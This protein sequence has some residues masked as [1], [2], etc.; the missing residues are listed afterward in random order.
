MSEEQRIAVAKAIAKAKL[1]VQASDAELNGGAAVSTPALAPPVPTTSDKDA[2]EEMGAAPVAVVPAPG[3]VPAG[4]AAGNDPSSSSDDDE[5]DDDDT[6]SGGGGGARG[7]DG[8]TVDQPTRNPLHGG[9][10]TTGAEVASAARFPVHNYFGEPPAEADETAGRP[11]VTTYPGGSAIFNSEGGIMLFLPTRQAVE[12]STLPIIPKYRDPEVPA[13]TVYLGSSTIEHPHR[14]PAGWALI[15]LHIGDPLALCC[16]D[17]FDGD[18]VIPEDELKWLMTWHETRRKGMSRRDVELQEQGVEALVGFVKGGVLPH[19]GIGREHVNIMTGMRTVLAQLIEMAGTKGLVNPDNFPDLQKF[20]EWMGSGHRLVNLRVLQGIATQLSTDTPAYRTSTGGEVAISGTSFPYPDEIDVSGGNIMATSVFQGDSHPSVMQISCK[21]SDAVSEFLTHLFFLVR[22]VDPD[23][24]WAAFDAVMQVPFVQTKITSAGK[25]KSQDKVHKGTPSKFRGRSFEWA[26]RE[27]ESRV[28]LFSSQTNRGYAAAANACALQYFS[29][30]PLCQGEIE[31]GAFPI[32]TEKEK[33]KLAMDELDEE[34]LE[35][36]FLYPQSC[37]LMANPPFKMEGACFVGKPV[38][39]PPGTLIDIKQECK[40]DQRLS[41]MSIPW[42]YHAFSGMTLMALI[43]DPSF[44]AALLNNAIGTMVVQSVDAGQ[45][46]MKRPPIAT[47]PVVI[48]TKQAV[49]WESLRLPGMT[50][51]QGGQG[52]FQLSGTGLVSH[53][54]TGVCIVSHTLWSAQTGLVAHSVGAAVLLRAN[55]YV[56]MQEHFE[57][58]KESFGGTFITTSDAG[59]ATLQRAIPLATYLKLP[60]DAEIKGWTNISIRH[61]KEVTADACRHMRSLMSGDHSTAQHV[62]LHTSNKSGKGH[63]NASAAGDEGAAEPGDDEGGPASKQSKRRAKQKERKENKQQSE[64]GASAVRDLSAKLAKMQRQLDAA[65]AAADKKHP[66][67]RELRKASQQAGGKKPKEANRKK[68]DS[69]DEDTKWV[70]TGKVD[71]SK[72]VSILRKGRIRE[73][74]E[75]YLPNLHKLSPLWAAFMDGEPPKGLLKEIAAANT[76]DKVAVTSEKSRAFGRRAGLMKGDAIKV[77]AALIAMAKAATAGTLIPAHEEGDSEFGTLC[78]SFQTPSST[79]PIE[80]PCLPEEQVWFSLTLEADGTSDADCAQRCLGEIYQHTDISCLYTEKNIHLNTTGGP[81]DPVCTFSSTKYC[82]EDGGD[83]PC[84]YMKVRSDDSPKED[85]SRELSAFTPVIQMN[86]NTVQAS[87]GEEPPKGTQL[88]WTHCTSQ[89]RFNMTQAQEEFVL[90]EVDCSG[91]PSTELW[92]FTVCYDSASGIPVCGSTVGE[93]P[94]GDTEV[95]SYSI[96]SLYDLLFN[97]NSMDN[98]QRFGALAFWGAV[99]AVFLVLLWKLI[100]FLTKTIQRGQEVNAARESAEA[101]REASARIVELQGNIERIYTAVASNDLEDDKATAMAGDPLKWTQEQAAAALNVISSAD[102]IIMEGWQKYEGGTEC[103]IN[104]FAKVDA[105]TM[106]SR[107]RD[108]IFAELS[109]SQ[110]T[111]PEVT[112]K[113]KR[114]FGLGRGV[115]KVSNLGTAAKRG[116]CTLAVAAIFGVA[117]GSMYGCAEYAKLWDGICQREVAM[118]PGCDSDHA[119]CCPACFEGNEAANRT[120]EGWA[121]GIGSTNTDVHCYYAP[122]VRMA[123]C[124]A[125]VADLSAQLTSLEENVSSVQAEA[126]NMSAKLTE[127]E[128]VDEMLMSVDSEVLGFF[129][130]LNGSVADVQSSLASF[131][132]ALA[133]HASQVT[134][135][136]ASLTTVAADVAKSLQRAA[137][138]DTKATSASSQV[139]TLTSTASALRADI[140]SIQTSYAEVANALG[141]LYLSASDHDTAITALEGEFSDVTA[142]LPGL[143]AGIDN[144]TAAAE[145]AADVA[146]VLVAGLSTRILAVENAA[147]QA[148]DAV[149]DL[150]GWNSTSAE[151]VAGLASLLTSY[152]STLQEVG[153]QVNRVNQSF[154]DFTEDWEDDVFDGYVLINAS[155]ANTQVKVAGIEAFIRNLTNAQFLEVLDQA[156]MLESDVGYLW[157]DLKGVNGTVVDQSADISELQAELRNVNET[158]QAAYN[159]NPDLQR[160]RMTTSLSRPDQQCDMWVVDQISDSVSTLDGTRSSGFRGT[161]TG[162]PGAV[163]CF[164]YEWQDNNAASSAFGAVKVKKAGQKHSATSGIWSGAVEAHKDNTYGCG[165][166]EKYYDGWVVGGLESIMPTAYGKLSLNSTNLVSQQKPAYNRDCVA[167]SQAGCPDCYDTFNGLSM[168]V[169]VSGYN[170]QPPG[171]HQNADRATVFVGDISEGEGFTEVETMLWDGVT[172]EAVDEYEGSGTAFRLS[173]LQC[174]TDNYRVSS[175]LPADYRMF[176][177]D[178]YANF[179][180]VAAPIG[181][182]SSSVPGGNIQAASK[183][184]LWDDALLNEEFCK[185]EYNGNSMYWKCATDVLGELLEGAQRSGYHR[186]GDTIGGC[187]IDFE[188][189]T[190]ILSCPITFDITCYLDGKTADFEERSTPVKPKVRCLED[191][192]DCDSTVD[193]YKIEAVVADKAFLTVIAKGPGLVS[194][195]MY[196]VEPAYGAVETDYSE[197]DDVGMALLPS[198]YPSASSYPIKLPYTGGSAR[199][200]MESRLVTTTTDMAQST[201]RTMYWNADYDT[202]SVHVEYVY[203]NGSRSS[204]TGAYMNIPA[205]NGSISIIDMLEYAGM[206]LA[207]LVALGLIALLAYCLVR[208]RGR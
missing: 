94:S 116:L 196:D 149:E 12:G 118:M 13:S 60:S 202:T 110:A 59:I 52:C 113:D 194:I 2:D 3:D 173:N 15:E 4:L 117:T 45:A 163:Y 33:L 93:T 25:Q 129:E 207:G 152:I 181:V 150:A 174:Y 29:T 132:G 154:I 143:E 146:R 153:S 42:P 206:A 89:G 134:A 142:L 205:Q 189:E 7:G 106:M 175:V 139:T 158:A 141:N 64:A 204:D 38:E 54:T 14:A 115:M 58:L 127:L 86:G 187:Q 66:T 128:Q 69:D 92:D 41:V 188:G 57:Q 101:S 11:R 177:S 131:D 32:M 36:L 200:C 8:L 148:L 164:G 97:F 44:S 96:F 102:E 184:D 26:S 180:G 168:G 144:A 51:V 28:V 24:C 27:V 76:G 23:A 30:H 75:L 61:F 20:C 133:L 191:G 17:E 19:D 65:K 121:D 84:E 161:I 151:V 10:R 85:N 63:Q 21:S 199:V 208:S 31:P 78:L 197:T 82:M 130:P 165:N 68:E 169:V 56:S 35:A 48:R 105:N 172:G 170:L 166:N 162:I 124:I 53:S 159:A 195:R 73:F 49:R 185:P 5:D 80:G 62:A 22:G 114:K 39:G 87:I 43:L 137:S 178:Y 77:T 109:G 160:R 67:R 125:S 171:G 46:I 71:D 18:P 156:K 81:N 95:V 107:R 135:L 182:T 145:D 183:T 88:V 72:M 47:A 155:L 98:L 126:A 91:L 79:T 50:R 176:L 203:T 55:E 70:P 136:G 123:E 120:Q 34:T 16:T 40:G 147:V 100:R 140:T 190:L 167:S 157:S 112:V 138:A 1:A 103:L 108:E 90:P 119:D 193:P 111:L 74:K 122:C 37:P 179:I 201:C 99:F 192:S 186:D 9:F 198:D 83:M 6:H 104:I